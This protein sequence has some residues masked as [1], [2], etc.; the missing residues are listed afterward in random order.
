MGDGIEVK[1]CGVKF[2]PP[3][4]VLN[5]LIKA[6]GKMHRRTM[7]LRN[8]NKNS[9]VDATVDELLTNPRHAKF[10]KC[11]PKFQLYRLV[12]IIRDKLSGMSL[13]DSLAKNDEIDR[14]DPEED[15]NKVDDETLRR[16]KSLMEDTFEKHVKKPGDPDFQYD[17]QVDFDEVEACEW[18]SEESDQ[19]F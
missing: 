5:Y 1:R 11:M 17:V 18:D 9:S 16:K 3:A 15:L 4:L 6:S 10:V 13:E 2:S 19:E 8:F 7:P 14:L 12:A